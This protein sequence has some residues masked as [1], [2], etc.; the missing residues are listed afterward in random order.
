MKFRWHLYTCTNETSDCENIPSDQLAPI[1]KGPI[2]DT[3]FYHTR[4]SV[5]QANQWY[6]VTFRAYRTNDSYGEVSFRFYVNLSPRPGTFTVNDK[7]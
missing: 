2:E 7:A 3:L 6:M 1:L 4:G 5:Y